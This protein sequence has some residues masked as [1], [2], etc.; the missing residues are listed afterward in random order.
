MSY[1]MNILRKKRKVLVGWQYFEQT[2]FSKDDTALHHQHP[3][4][5]KVCLSLCV[6][7]CVCVCG[8]GVF[9][10]CVW[11]VWCVSVYL[12]VCL[13]VCVFAILSGYCSVY[14]VSSLCDVRAPCEICC[15]HTV[16]L[17]CITVID[18]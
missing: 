7:V 8:F 15:V 5:E 12:S 11:L 6:C 16:Y 9:V 18:R 17:V 10:V 13:C 3:L 2:V 4:A 14:L 1:T